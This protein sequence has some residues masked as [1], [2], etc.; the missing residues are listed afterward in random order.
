MFPTQSAPDWRD[1]VTI[2]SMSF[3]DLWTCPSCGRRFAKPNTQHVCG[4]YSVDERLEAASPEIQAL[5]QGLYSLAEGC[6]EFFAEATKTAISFKNPG[7]FLAVALQ[8]RG[9]GISFWLGRPLR[10]RRIR[11]VYTVSPTNYAHHMRVD[12]LDELDEQLKNWLCES[13]FYVS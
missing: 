4:R 9:L 5:Y 13:Y 12:S 11:K 7:I 2:Q 3:A 10:H 8:K 1:T 6:G